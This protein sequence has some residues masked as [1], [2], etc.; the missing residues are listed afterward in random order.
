M[1]KEKKKKKRESKN[2]K[3]AKVLEEKTKFNV[4]IKEKPKKI[5]KDL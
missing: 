3:K 5:E 4:P 1:E 2:K